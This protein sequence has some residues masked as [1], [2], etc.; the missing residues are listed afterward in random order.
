VQLL[1]VSHSNHQD[2][3]IGL[4]CLTALTALHVNHMGLDQLPAE[5]SAL[6]NM[7]HVCASHNWLSGAGSTLS[8]LLQGWP[9][10]SVLELDNVSDKHGTLVLPSQLT[11]CRWVATTAAGQRAGSIS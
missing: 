8:G 7:V 9:Q 3:P 11:A 10:L 1:D 5:L 4:S 6:S 2:L